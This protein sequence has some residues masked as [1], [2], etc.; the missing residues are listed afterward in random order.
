MKLNDLVLARTPGQTFPFP[1]LKVLALNA[2]A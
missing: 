2:F 1:R